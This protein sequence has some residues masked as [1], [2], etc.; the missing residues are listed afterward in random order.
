MKRFAILSVVATLILLLVAGPTSATVPQAQPSPM[1][2]QFMSRAEFEQLVDAGVLQ[3][4]PAPPAILA[5]L[6]HDNNYASDTGVT[7]MK[8]V[9]WYNPVCK[10]TN[11]S[12]MYIPTRVGS[13]KFGWE[14]M[15][16]K[17]NVR[18][19][20]LVNVPTSGSRD[21]REGDRETYSG[22]FAYSGFPVQEIR[23]IVDTSRRTELG[24]PPDGKIVGG[25]TAYCVG[26]PDL[27]PDW[28]N[29]I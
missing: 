15:K 24:T 4:A 19:C 25:I 12:G 20:K 7:P 18:N 29:S 28:V 22:I 3:N 5:Q 9:A 23:V 10:S 16:A 8:P 13:I 21:K 11:S 2:L 1:G 6:M 14:K 27:C 26:Y 17:H